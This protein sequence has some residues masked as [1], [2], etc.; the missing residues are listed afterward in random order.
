MNILFLK[1][2]PHLLSYFFI[3]TLLQKCIK[4]PGLPSLDLGTRHTWVNTGSCSYGT[5]KLYVLYFIYQKFSRYFQLV[6]KT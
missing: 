6:S 5:S 3:F 2:P 4:F 1:N